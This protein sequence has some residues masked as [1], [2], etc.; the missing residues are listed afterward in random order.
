MPALGR[1]LTPF[2]FTL[3]LGTVWGRF[4]YVTDAFVGII[5]GVVA[6]VLTGFWAKQNVHEQD[7]GFDVIGSVDTKNVLRERA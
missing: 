2:V 4:H 5:V 7:S 6:L 1:V 3:V